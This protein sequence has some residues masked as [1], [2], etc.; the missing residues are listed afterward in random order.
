LSRFVSPDN[1]ELTVADLEPSSNEKNLLNKL[2]K[3]SD[4]FALSK[5][6]D[7]NILQIKR[8][9]KFSESKPSENQNMTR[10]NLNPIEE[11]FEK[12]EGSDTIEKPAHCA[13][14]KCYLHKTGEENSQIYI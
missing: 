1:P 6:S 7:D 11:T 10:K 9:L 2:S 8:T 4:T 3:G 5:S 13:T 12:G 14:C